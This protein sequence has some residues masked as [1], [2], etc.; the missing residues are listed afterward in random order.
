MPFLSYITGVHVE[1]LDMDRR[2]LANLTAQ[3]CSVLRRIETVRHGGE[4]V[5]VSMTLL[6][7]RSL[8]LS[9]AWVYQG[10]CKDPRDAG[11][12]VGPRGACPNGVSGFSCIKVPGSDPSLRRGGRL[13][14]PSN[15]YISQVF[16]DAGAELF[17]YQVILLDPEL[18]ADVIDEAHARLLFEES[19]IRQDMDILRQA[20]REAAVAMDACPGGVCTTGASRSSSDGDSTV[21][22]A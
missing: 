10:C 2:A 9:L 5:D 1:D 17:D 16:G 14:V 20:R 3:I 12:S 15:P 18:A 6:V 19:L 7:L 22:A 8:R 13:L 11:F 4:D 21:D